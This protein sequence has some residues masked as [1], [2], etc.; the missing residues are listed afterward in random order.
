MF[1]KTIYRVVPESQSLTKLGHRRPG[2]PVAAGNSAYVRAYDSAELAAFCC[3]ALWAMRSSAAPTGRRRL[4][5]ETLELS[6]GDD[7]R[8]QATRLPHWIADEDEDRVWERMRATADAAGL[9]C[10]YAPSAHAPDLHVVLLDTAHP[11]FR[12]AVRCRQRLLAQPALERPPDEA[13]W[14]AASC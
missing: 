8:T 10:V 2:E 6:L 7:L 11:A 1:H 5:R 9:L 3:P 14:H 12:Q 13:P 4:V